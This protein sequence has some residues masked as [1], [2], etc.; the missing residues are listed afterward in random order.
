MIIL[1]VEE[2]LKKYNIKN[3]RQRS[4]ILQF[5]LDNDE[6]CKILA[7]LDYV[8]NEGLDIDLSTIYRTVDKFCE[9]NII[10][11]IY[12]DS[13]E[14]G[15]IFKRNNH[16]HVVKCV[17]CNKDIEIECPIEEAYRILKV[18]DGIEMNYHCNEASFDVI[19]KECSIKNQRRFK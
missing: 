15:Y 18:R 3:T 11:K 2:I 17:N 12:L 1:Q 6:P 8:K 14:Y 13:K 7:I 10:E 19:C 5:F 9:L 4:I 16:K